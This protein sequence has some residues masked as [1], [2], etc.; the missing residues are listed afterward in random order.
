MSIILPNGHRVSSIPKEKIFVLKM[1]TDQEQRITEDS[2]LG[3]INL[4]LKLN[5]RVAELEKKLATSVECSES[6]A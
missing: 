3:M 2:I 6:T 5:N 1:G 4:L